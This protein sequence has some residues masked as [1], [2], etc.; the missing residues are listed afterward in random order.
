MEKP[1]VKSPQ[2]TKSGEITDQET[3]D[4]RFL[5]QN[6]RDIENILKLIEDG[7]DQAEAERRLLDAQNSVDSQK[8]GT[9]FHQHSKGNRKISLNH[10]TSN[11]LKLSDALELSLKTLDFGKDLHR[12]LEDCLEK[13]IEVLQTIKKRRK[14]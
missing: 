1:A 3:E 8:Q 6:A 7:T 13:R 10:H 12:E 9:V 2:K 11:L 4:Q 5:A 14:M